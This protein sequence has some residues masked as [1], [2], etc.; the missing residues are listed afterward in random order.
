M[1]RTLEKDL[2][3]LSPVALS[4]A[5]QRGIDPRAIDQRAIYSFNDSE[6]SDEI[7]SSESSEC[8]RVFDFRD[9]QRGSQN[10]RQIFTSGQEVAEG[11]KIGYLDEIAAKTA[12]YWFFMHD[13]CLEGHRL[14]ESDHRHKVRIRLS[15]TD[16]EQ[17][18]RARRAEKLLNK[19]ET[20]LELSERAKNFNLDINGLMEIFEL[21]WRDD[22]TEQLSLVVLL[23]FLLAAYGGVHM[24]AWNYQFPSTVEQW[25]WRGSCISL[26]ASGFILALLFSVGSVVMEFCFQNLQRW[27]ET[28]IGYLLL[29][30]LGILGICFIVARL[31]IGVEAFISLRAVPIGVYAAVPWAAYI[32]HI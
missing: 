12:L 6:M 8:A 11:V 28:C 3:D 13:T 10:L 23:I 30:G 7:E 26:A 16:I 32:P 20:G 5:R 2:K 18:K 29:A 22:Y 19:S 25:F 17:L 9:R 15:E 4:S 14:A 24:T 27:A 1:K 31:F 21:P